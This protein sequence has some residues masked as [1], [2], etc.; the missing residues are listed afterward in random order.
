MPRIWGLSKTAANYRQ[1]PRPELRCDACRFM[2][3]KLAVGSCR[4]VR[5]VISASYT[6]DQFAP[7]R[8]TRGS[9]GPP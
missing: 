2:F 9:S 3:P 4:Y 6:C 7:L 8:P 1:A 5:G